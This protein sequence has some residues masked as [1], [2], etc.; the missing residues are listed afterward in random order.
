MQ[1]DQNAEQHQGNAQPAAVVEQENGRIHLQAQIGRQDERRRHQHNFRQ[2]KGERSD[3]YE[4][5]EQTN[6]PM[7]TGS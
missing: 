7:G 1:A 6:H 3:W 4:Y 2:Q 5:L